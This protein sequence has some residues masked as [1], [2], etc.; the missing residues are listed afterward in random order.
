MARALTRSP[1]AHRARVRRQLALVAL[2]GIAPIVASYLAYYFWPRDARVNYGALRAEPAPDIRGRTLDGR[3]FALADL[4]GKWV[5]LAAAGGQCDAVCE[6][7]LHA[8]RQART[9]Q[10]A[11]MDRITRVWL[12][13]DDAAPPPALVAEHPDLVVARVEPAGVARLPD[14]G[15]GLALVD[16]LGNVVLTWPADPDI[17]AMAKDIARLLRASRIG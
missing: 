9:I 8:G 7:A 12:V 16:P 17:K 5:V 2:I 10:N 15:R 3:P 1:E 6:R 13:T 4:R 11:D 14:G